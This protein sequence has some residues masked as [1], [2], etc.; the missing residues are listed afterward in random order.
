MIEREAKAAGVDP[1]F[2]IAIANLESSFSHVPAND[3]N[4]TSYGPF[5]VNKS[6]ALANGVDYDEMKKNPDLA[7]R[8]GIM[9]IARHAKNPALEGDPLRILAAHRYGENSEYARTGDESKIDKTLAGY[10][11]KFLEHFPDEE[12][13]GTVYK[14]QDEKDNR[15]ESGERSSSHQ[16]KEIG[17]AHV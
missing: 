1:D 17:R 11:S 6:T 10:M 12:Y 13:A 16:N 14:S 8:T 2:A 5:Q 9:N 7:V 3:P 4:S 15:Q